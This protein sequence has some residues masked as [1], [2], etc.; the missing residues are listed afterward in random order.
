M[1]HP[2]PLTWQRASFRWPQQAHPS[3]HGGKLA[4][5]CYVV[6]RD[7]EPYKGRLQ[8]LRGHADVTR[9]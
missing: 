2:W 9:Q 5:I 7:G 3:Q 4:R 6:L 8:E 1:L